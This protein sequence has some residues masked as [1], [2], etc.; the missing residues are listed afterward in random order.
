[1]AKPLPLPVWDR[2]T[3]KLV[4]EWMGDHQ[5]T[6]ESRPRASLA[7]W[8]KSHPLFDWAYAAYQNTGRSARQIE[9]FVREYHIDMSEF[10]PVRL[11]RGVFRS[12]VPAG[13]PQVSLGTWRD[14][15]VRRGALP[16][17]G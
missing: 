10:E 15:R 14:G 11:I 17:L 12:T 13:G 8:I 1:M 3:D 2:R 4:M 9:P 7:Q 6:Y 16:R 5:T